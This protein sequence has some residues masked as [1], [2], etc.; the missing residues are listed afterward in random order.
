MEERLPG[1]ESPIQVNEAS[2]EGRYGRI[3]KQMEEAIALFQKNGYDK[4]FKR[5]FDEYVSNVYLLKT[6]CSELLSLE[7]KQGGGEDYYRSLS[8]KLKDFTALLIKQIGLYYFFLLKKPE[9]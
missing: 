8:L 7:A 2:A 4:S 3:L 1:S 6:I 5:E 9:V